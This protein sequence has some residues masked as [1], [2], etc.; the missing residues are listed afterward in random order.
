M[1]FVW[2]Q[3]G[4]FGAFSPYYVIFSFYSFLSFCVEYF[5][6]LQ[7]LVN[8]SVLNFSTPITFL[9]NLCKLLLLP[10]AFVLYFFIF[11][12]LIFVFFL[13][14]YIF[15]I[16]CAPIPTFIQYFY[17]IF[18]ILLVGNIVLKAECIFIFIL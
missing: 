9:K 17:F 4:V 11:I 2:K 14:Y 1:H 15:S 12:I 5:Y 16:L 10:Y 18:E 6:I 13:F 3:F 7:V 8:F